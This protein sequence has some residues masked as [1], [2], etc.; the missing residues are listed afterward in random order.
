MTRR[1]ASRQPRRH[2]AGRWWGAQPRSAT[3]RRKGARTSRRRSA[4]PRSA[5]RRVAC[6][7]GMASSAA[8]GR[9]LRFFRPP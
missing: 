2:R 6:T 7:M 8:E 5:A 9:P 1:P 3:A 4:A